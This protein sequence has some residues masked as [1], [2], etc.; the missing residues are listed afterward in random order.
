MKDLKNALQKHGFLGELDDSPEAIETYSH[1]ASMFELRPQ[2][3]ARPRDS[4]DV[5]R[6]VRFFATCAR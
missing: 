3:V 6:L 4:A 1:D 2:I 5:Q